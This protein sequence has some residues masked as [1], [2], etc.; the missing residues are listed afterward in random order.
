MLRNDKTPLQIVKFM[1]RYIIETLDEL[2]QTAP[3]N[4]FI[5]GEVNAFVECLEILSDWKDYLKYGIDDIE[6]VYPVK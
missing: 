5:Q 2:T 4:D 3:L 6:K 1:T